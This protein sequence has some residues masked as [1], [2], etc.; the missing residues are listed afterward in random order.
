MSGSAAL[1]AAL[2][3][4]IAESDRAVILDFAE[5]RFIGSTALGVV[6]VTAKYLENRDSKLILCS[7]SDPVRRVLRIT[8]FERF[9]TIHA[10][11]AGAQ[12]SVEG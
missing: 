12:A 9:L 10:T 5:V 11:R 6:I 4:T 7:L 3:R 8:G 1:A 2:Q